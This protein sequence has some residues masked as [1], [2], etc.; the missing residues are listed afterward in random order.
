MVGCRRFAP[1]ARPRCCRRRE[2]QHPPPSPPVGNAPSSHCAAGV[3]GTGLR[4]HLGPSLRCDD[5]PSGPACAGDPAR[6]IR[7]VGSPEPPDMLTVGWS[8]LRP[9]KGDLVAGKL[10]CPRRQRQCS[11][12][13]AKDADLAHSGIRQHRAALAEP[14]G[15]CRHAGRGTARNALP[16]RPAPAQSN[17]VSCAC[18]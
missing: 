10:S 7:L 18:L 5:G 13:I 1:L 15:A 8:A 6:N 4:A 17:E 2:R 12:T 9:D 14:Y 3:I 16:D 11:T